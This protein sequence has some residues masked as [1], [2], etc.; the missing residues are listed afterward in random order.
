M[1]KSRLSQ[2]AKDLEHKQ[3][4][5]YFIAMDVHKNSYHIALRRH[6]GFIQTF[7]APADPRQLIQRQSVFKQVKFDFEVY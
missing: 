6:D 3:G 5:S 4:V 2:L 7:L 1:G